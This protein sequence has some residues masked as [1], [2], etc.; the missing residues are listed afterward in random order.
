MGNRPLAGCG[1]KVRWGSTCGGKDD[2]SRCLLFVDERYYCSACF[3]KFKAQ[4]LIPAPPPVAPLEAEQFMS[5]VKKLQQHRDSNLLRFEL[6]RRD[7][8]EHLIPALPGLPLVLVD[9]IFSFKTGGFP[10][11]K[12]HYFVTNV[13]LRN[14]LPEALDYWDNGNRKTAGYHEHAF[15]KYVGSFDW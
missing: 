15:Q 12:C 5:Q 11:L 2:H 3:S 1:A 8:M 13:A 7:V 14:C 4:G 9:L 10:C 6:L